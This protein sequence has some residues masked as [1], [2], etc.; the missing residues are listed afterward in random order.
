MYCP[1]CLNAAIR[2][3]DKGVVDLVINKKQKDTGRFLFNKERETLEE[4]VRNFEV[5]VEEFFSWYAKFQNKDPIE[6]FELLTNAFVCDNG[7]PI[8]LNQK[9]N[10]IDLL[11][12]KREV[13]KIV[14]KLSKKYGLTIDI[15]D[16]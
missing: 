16:L 14:T 7:C 9:F 12:P 1:N 11:I 15:E 4:I 6:S 3:G 2:L 5:K 13:V 8:N 10:V